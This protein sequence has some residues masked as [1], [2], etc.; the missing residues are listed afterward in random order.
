MVLAVFF[1]FLK[2][3]DNPKLPSA[4]LLELIR[5]MY[6]F[7]DAEMS[8]YVEKYL[9]PKPKLSPQTPNLNPKRS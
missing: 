5:V 4:D 1:L 7:N 9:F 3:M 6:D 2:Q 8:A